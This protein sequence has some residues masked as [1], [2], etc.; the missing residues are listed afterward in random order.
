MT[1]L[2]VAGDR[3]FELNDLIAAGA[4]RAASRRA[5]VRARR[6]AEL[7]ARIAAGEG[8]EGL[9]PE[10]AQQVLA[11]FSDVSFY[12]SGLPGD[13]R[14]IGLWD[15]AMREP[16]GDIE[17]RWTLVEAASSSDRQDVVR[18]LVTE[19]PVDG[20]WSDGARATFASIAAWYAD[21]WRVAEAFLV[22]GGDRAEGYSNSGIRIR[23]DQARLRGGYDREAAARVL[24]DILSAA[25]HL[26][27]PEGGPEALKAAGATDELRALGAAL[28]SRAQASDRSPE[29]R[30]DDFG[31]ASWA[32]G[33]AG[34]RDL[35]LGAARV[36]AALTPLAVAERMSLHSNAGSVSP[37]EAAEIANGF[38]TWPVQRLY[39]L[40]ARD[41]ALAVAFLA[42]RDRY[43]AEL[44]AGVTPDP[45]WLAKP[46][47][48]YQLK[49]V[50]PVLQQRRA[51]S[52]AGALLR[53]LQAEP[54]DWASAGAEELMML[55]AIAGEG[56][57]VE[58][59]FDEAVRDLDESE[60]MATWAALQLV[61]GRRAADAELRLDRTNPQ[62]P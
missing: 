5:P 14:A 46:N 47:L 20:P 9:S 34:D 45:S 50:V 42:G 37:A 44:E 40:G 58:A 1:D 51:V 21:D 52:D 27:W 59:I 35:A 17:L 30:T 11:L 55:A 29:D 49:L 12:D 33:A 22:S 28:V 56:G 13:A 10:E 18:R 15:I 31:L 2:A 7:A 23:I 3:G 4:W 19:A 48:A 60:D 54:A 41:E 8:H 6:I 62:S 26:P 32:Y 57:Q 38:G 43:L 61:I 36:G 53:R 25:E 39:E 24:A 16:V